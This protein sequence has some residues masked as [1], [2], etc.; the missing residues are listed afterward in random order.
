MRPEAVEVGDGNGEILCPLR[1]RAL[2]TP[3]APAIALSDKVLGYAELDARVA[4]AARRLRVAGCEIGTHAALYLPLNERYVV[5]LL[6]LLRIGAVACP[7]STRLPPQSARSLAERVACSILISEDEGLA[8]TLSPEALDIDSVSFAPEE[9]LERVWLSL[10]QAATIVFTSG[11][12]GRPK[13]ALHTF[14]NHYYSA[15]GSGANIML[16]PGDRW[17]LSL[18]LY[19]VGGLSILF[20]CLM[21]GAT[22]AIPGP[23][24]PLG[25]SIR[26][27]GATHIS[28]VTT[29]LRRLLEERVHLGGVKTIL[30]GGGPFPEAFTDEAVSRGLPVHTSYGLTEMASQVTTTPPGASLSGLRTSGRVLPHRE[31]VISGD[32]EILVRGDTL[33]AGYVRDDGLGRPVDE[34]GWFHTG[35]LGDLDGEGF[36]RVH[37]RKDNLLISGG[38]NIQPEEIEEHLERLEGVERAVVV[39]VPDEYFGERPAAF[40]LPA[41]GGATPRGLAREL[42]RGLPRFKVPVAFYGWPEDVDPGKTKIDRPFFR[43]RA[44]RRELG[45]EA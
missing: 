24:E 29:Q 2:E 7:V 39:P 17:L 20:R 6:A 31:V 8:D 25:G 37:G 45:D 35:D 43:D 36:L 33:F 9:Q 4:S 41:A 13:A 38:E 28:L 42:E 18:P 19:H 23:G 21:A 11:S 32:G 1:E 16:S 30:L 15:L 22:M 40:V 27:L 12:S 10:D 3:D 44:G 26:D 14:G 5:L 34:A